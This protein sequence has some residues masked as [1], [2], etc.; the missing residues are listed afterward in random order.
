MNKEDTKWNAASIRPASMP[1]PLRSRLAAAMVD[2]EKEVKADRF[3]ERKLAGRFKPAPMPAHVA[4]AC[5]AR[6][7]ARQLCGAK[8]YSR[9]GRRCGYATAAAAVAL[10]CAGGLGLFYVGEPSAKQAAAEPS[11]VYAVAERSIAAE[12][13][14]SV[15]ITGSLPSEPCRRILY[16][17]SLV[18]QGANR[19]RII[20]RVPRHEDIPISNEVI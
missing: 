15:Q 14:H 20:I 17:D 6:L 7:A 2:A 9:G 10:C 11:A 13:P 5:K 19:T 1:A 4:E 18:I 12:L 3:F 8:P 16:Q